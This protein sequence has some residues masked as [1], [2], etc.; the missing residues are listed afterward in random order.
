MKQ[1]CAICHHEGAD[2]PE[3]GHLLCLSTTLDHL[4]SQA[5]GREGDGILLPVCP[6]H[7]VDIYRGRLPGV[8]MAWQFA[9][10]LPGMAVPAAR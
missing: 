2:P 8:T 5:A 1:P 10:T 9:G 6:T 7:A 4:V 3:S